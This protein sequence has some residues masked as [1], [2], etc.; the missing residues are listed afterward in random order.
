MFSL[1]PLNPDSLIRPLVKTLIGVMGFQVVIA[2]AN[3]IFPPDMSRAQTASAVALDRNG[4]WLRA[5]PV[6]NGR[7]RIRADLDRTDPSFICRLL[8]VED[9]RFYFHPGVDATSIVRALLSNIHAGNIVSGGSTITMQ[10][11]R[12]LS[13]H[14]RDYGNKLIEALRAVQLEM[15]YSKREILALYLTLAPYGGNLEGVRAASLSYFGHEPESLT[16]GEQA[17][18]IS[19]PQAPEARRPDRKPANALKARNLILKRMTEANI[20][21]A[22]QAGEAMNEPMVTSRFAFP[23]LAWHTA[24]RLARGVKGLQATVVTT[25]DANLQT[26]L[27]AMAAATAKDQGPNSSV[28]IIVVDIK[29]RGVRASVGGG[30]LDRPGG[31]M[32]MTRAIRSPG[33]ALKPFI[34]GFA[35][36]DGVVAPDTRLMDAPTRFGDY[37]PEDFDR[38]FHGEVSAK[39]ALINSLNVP[40][41][42]VLNRIGPEAFQGRLEAVNVPLI[43][44]K[45]GLK[46]SGLALA[47]G[48]EGIRISDLALLYAALGDH[49]LA[50]PL[51]YTLADEKTSG[52]QRL[53]RPEAADRVISILRETPPPEGR[54]PGPLMKNAN[55]P[56]FKTGT[57]YGYRDALAVGVAGGYAVLVWT[58]RPDGGARADQTG[59]EASAPLLFDVFDQLQAPSQ[60][61]QSI[62]PGNAPKGLKMMSGDTGKASI[63]FPPNN[64]TVYVEVKSD[65]VKLDV[66]RPLKLSARGIRPVQW[67]VDGQPL[68]LDENGEWSWSPPTEGFFELSV[69]DAQGHE[70]KSHV[71]VKAIRAGEEN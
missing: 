31:W 36:E 4:A 1:K 12:L 44:P 7:W 65:A 51:A 63:L 57:S 18:L 52:G 17:L 42:A 41:V 20:I 71:R 15:R 38:V 67:Y 9:E 35:F 39:E 29:T 49:G 69:I 58:G 5:L 46:D 34:Y 55:R 8:R 27:E 61:P 16:L 68:K 26:R 64:A 40:A 56:A 23:T 59:R 14:P 62:A 32:D 10:T 3:L 25:I 70:D 2:A 45:S 37:Q 54:L 66:A 21:G 53:M 22:S 33:S 48:G 30:G 47:L 6:D 60:V 28:A 11:A 24:G 19:L 43:V 13:P 50:R